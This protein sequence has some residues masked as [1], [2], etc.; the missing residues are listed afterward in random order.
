MS[1][2]SFKREVGGWDIASAFENP[3]LNSVRPA[4]TRWTQPRPTWLTTTPPPPSS[5]NG[6]VSRSRCFTF[7]AYEPSPAATPRCRWFFWPEHR[8]TSASSPPKPTWRPCGRTAASRWRRE[9]AAALRSAASAPDTNS[10]M[11]SV[12]PR[13]ACCLLMWIGQP[14]QQ[15]AVWMDGSTIRASTPQQ[16]CL[17]CVEV[18][19]PLFIPNSPALVS[20]NIFIDFHWESKSFSILK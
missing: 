16:S 14:W 5:E 3:T 18:R 10:Q 6:A 19:S 4:S 20:G 11:C 9:A 2:C 12:I 13:G 17:R 8:S 1:D 15:R 7:C